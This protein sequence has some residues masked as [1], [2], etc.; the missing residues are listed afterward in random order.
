MTSGA[1]VRSLAPVSI[2]MGGSINGSPLATLETIFFCV[3]FFLLQ[4]PNDFIKSRPSEIIRRYSKIFFRSLD[5]G[6]N[7]LEG[8]VDPNWRL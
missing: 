6:S 5:A 8:I 4:A 7:S 2:T 1:P 3:F